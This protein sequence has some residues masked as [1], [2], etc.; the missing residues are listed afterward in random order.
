MAE[1][2][3]IIITRDGDKVEIEDWIKEREEEQKNKEYRKE[4]KEEIRKKKK[5]IKRRE[6]RW[7]IIPEYDENPS[8][9]KILSNEEINDKIVKEYIM[10]KDNVE[11]FKKKS[12]PDDVISFLKELRGRAVSLGVVASATRRTN[13]SISSTL[14]RLYS[15]GVVTRIPTEKNTKRFLWKLNPIYQRKEVEEIKSIFNKV[16]IDRRNKKSKSLPEI[17]LPIDNK[18]QTLSSKSVKMTIE[19]NIED[20]LRFLK[21][22]K[23]Q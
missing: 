23:E 9:V 6:E 19:G 8:E 16:L 17:S 7:V 2:E 12:I 3:G 11:D 14:S 4:E 13:K 5:I 10:S 18:I 20:I 1:K 22:I 21:R 15:T